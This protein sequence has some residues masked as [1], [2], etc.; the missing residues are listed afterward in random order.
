MQEV[1]N[2]SLNTGMVFVM[3]HMNKDAFRTQWKSFGFGEKT[4]IDLPAES[5]GLISNVNTNYD[6]NFANI[7]FGQGVAVTPIEMIRALS[8]LANG[9]HLVTPHVA[10]QIQYADGISKTLDFPVTGQLINPETDT[11]I[12]KMLVTVFDHYDQGTV[13]MDHYSIAAK[14]GTAQI[15]DPKTAGYY[16]DRNVHTFMAYFPATHPKF[17]VFFYN[18]YPKNGAKYS[19]DT[20]LPPFIDFAKFL[21][22]YYDVPPDR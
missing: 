21:I 20:L 9:G 7:S 12:T 17:I 13:K 4:G 11:T 3:Q 19:S 18:Y 22:N 5:T 16:P 15:P 8:V 10:S 6:V 2:Q 14:T 1:L